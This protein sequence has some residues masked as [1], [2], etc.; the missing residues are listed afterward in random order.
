MKA[1]GGPGAAP[2][3]AAPLLVSPLLLL[4]PL[5]VSLSSCGK[6][7]I[8]DVQAGFELADAAWFAEEETLFLFYEVSA[9]Q[10]LGEPSVIELSYTTDDGRLDWTPVSELPAVHPHVAVDCGTKTLCGSTSLHVPLEPRDVAI[11]LR[12][13]RDGELAL[14]ADTD[15]NVVGPGPAHKNRS[16]IVYGVFD[17]DNQRVQWRGRHQ[18]PTLRNHDA[19]NLGLRRDFL[20]HDQRYGTA[21][22]TSSENPYGYGRGCPSIFS[23]AGLDDVAT[24]ERAVFDVDDLPSAASDDATVCADATVTDGT[25]SFTTT[26]FARKNPQVRDAFPALRSPI[27]DATPIR[28][29]LEPCDRSIS[30]QHEAMQRQRLFMGSLPS[31]CVDDWQDEGFVDELV[32][33]LTA[34]VEAERPAGNDMVL[35]IG[36]HQDEAGLSE[37]VEEALAQIVPEERD[38][39]SPRLAGAF[40]FDSDIHRLSLP[41]LEPVTLWCPAALPDEDATQLPDASTLTCAIAPDN[42]DLELGPFSFGSLPVLPSREQYLDFIDTYSEAQAGT[43][44]SLSFRTPEFATTSQHVEIGDYGV[45]TFLNDEII[46]ADADDAFSYCV[47]DESYLF[48][49]RSQ[50][51]QSDAFAALIAQDCAAGSIPEEL[52]TAAELGLLPI[53][54]LGE[55]HGY[56]GEGT[57]ELGIFWDFPFLLRMEY[58]IFAAG[59][60]SA[61]GLSVPFGFAESGESYLGTAM[62]T[63]DEFP[64]EDTLT[65]CTRFCD[66]PTFDSAGVYHISDDFRSTYTSSCYLPDY[67]SPGDSGFPLDP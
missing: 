7:P 39:S 23:S 48:V 22:I 29:F 49:F 59:S 62:W 6:V 14:D 64:L 60:V 54:W 28:F 10:G 25:G 34:A 35:V 33:S 58:E 42:P 31:T 47:G 9:E 4:S 5:L 46:S 1:S 8:Y 3:A 45:V 26:A 15:F 67:P 16:F 18:L 44:Q 30:S 36:L 13:H 55:W 52:C 2:L 27:R 63:T 19:Q 17:E 38:R 65:Q 53:E 37:V 43:V 51:M 32:V 20:I 57:Y 40:V 50:I 56:F 12:Y 24:D 21:E 61:F 41:E 66:H 11:R